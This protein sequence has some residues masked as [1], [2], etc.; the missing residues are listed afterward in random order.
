MPSWLTWFIK[1]SFMLPFFVAA[2]LPDLDRIITSP[3]NP[4]ALSWQTEQQ[5]W[6]RSDEV[7]WTQR[8]ER[9]RLN[10]A[11][12]H[13]RF[14]LQWQL[15]H[16]QLHW[17]A[18]S[19]EQQS[20]DWRFAW[21]HWLPHDLVLGLHES[22]LG[23]GVGS[24]DRY[25]YLA[26][27][28]PPSPRRVSLHF[29]D[30]S[31]SPPS[32][33]CATTWHW[34]LQVDD[35]AWQ[36]Q[37]APELGYFSQRL[38]LGGWQWQ[39]QINPGSQPELHWQQTPY[40]VRLAA[41]DW[42][43]RHHQFSWQR[44]RW[45]LSYSTFAYDSSVFVTAR[46]SDE[47]A[48]W[49]VGGRQRANGRLQLSG[50]QFALAY[51]WPS[52][53]LQANLLVLDLEANASHFKF[54]PLIPLPRLQSQLQVEAESLLLPQ[55]SLGK[56]WQVADLELRLQLSQLVPIEQPRVRHFTRDQET[57]QPTLTDPGASSGSSSPWPSHW[58]GF[59]WSLSTAL[60]F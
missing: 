27:T 51:H 19:Y 48:S 46:L 39:T 58:S 41:S 32:P 50:S 33:S 10:W 38:Q 52:L 31:A 34:Q 55:L 8:Q 13:W 7:N 15:S 45:W 60:A 17:Q 4:A 2:M 11:Q 5:H 42:Q 6:L 1:G 59:S 35:L 22:G 12:D 44:Q 53:W 57:G 25:T 43:F 23:L 47:Q 54:L 30:A 56:S 14:N 40:F 36:W 37:H 49:L 21:Q 9:L 3:D 18:L 20:L 16:Q 28:C 24:Q 26:I 29:Q